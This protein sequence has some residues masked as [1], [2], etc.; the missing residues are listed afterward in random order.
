MVQG[1]PHPTGKFRV[2]GPLSNLGEFQSA[3]QCPA[4]KPMVRADRCRVW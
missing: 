1:D 3:F 2:I 4:G